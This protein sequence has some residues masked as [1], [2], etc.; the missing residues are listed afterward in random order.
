MNMIDNNNN[1]NLDKP[2]AT[3]QGGQSWGVGGREPPYFGQGV[4]GS[5]GVV[6]GRGLVDGSWHIIISYHV[7]EVYLKVETFYEK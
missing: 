6:A 2:Y 4:V 7:Q 1:S 5:E 3:M